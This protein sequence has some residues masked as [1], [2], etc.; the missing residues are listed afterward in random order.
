L[1]PNHFF[2]VCSR[3]DET[4][5]YLFV[6]SIQQQQQQHHQQHPQNVGGN[7]IPGMNMTGPMGNIPQ[8]QQGKLHFRS[9]AQAKN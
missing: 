5:N 6:H 3:S 8:H 1:K 4:K 9:F 2:L 7:G